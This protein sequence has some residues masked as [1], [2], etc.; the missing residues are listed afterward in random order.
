MAQSGSISS[1][2]FPK[3]YPTNF[4][5]SWEL[6]LPN[7]DYIGLQFI[8][9]D[10]RP[11]DISGRCTDYVQIVPMGQPP[12]SQKYFWL[13][14]FYDFAFFSDQYCGNTIPPMYVG[15]AP[16][17][18][19]TMHS[20]STNNGFKGFNMTWSDVPNNCIPFP[21]DPSF[22][23]ISNGTTYQCESFCTSVP[24]KNGG[25]CVDS[26][27]G[28]TCICPDGYTGKDCGTSKKNFTISFKFIIIFVIFK[29]LITVNQILACMEAF[30]SI[31]RV[32]LLVSARWDFKGRLVQI[33]SFF[34]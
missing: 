24:C 13:F 29:L 21:C 9:F 6:R 22:H 17:A 25:T 28:F 11:P 19:V 8:S 15:D 31:Q 18:T 33:V 3:N 26:K 14:F 16:L 20:G 30:A 4:D 23:C 7:Q 12:R 34:R 10:L 1:P 2:L 27:T 5:C 32:D